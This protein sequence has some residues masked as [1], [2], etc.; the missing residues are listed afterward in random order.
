LVNYFENRSLFAKDNDTLSTVLYHGDTLHCNFD[1]H[2][3]V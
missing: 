1:V 2:S 3:R